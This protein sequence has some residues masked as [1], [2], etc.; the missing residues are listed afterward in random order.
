MLPLQ[1]RGT[2]H[3]E[4]CSKEVPSAPCGRADLRTPVQPTFLRSPS[5]GEL[6]SIIRAL[7]ALSL[8]LRAHWVLVWHPLRGLF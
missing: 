8:L 2:L 4:V 3:P 5:T 6:S 1:M 7:G